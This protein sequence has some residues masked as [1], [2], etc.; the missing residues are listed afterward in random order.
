VR[1]EGSGGEIDPGRRRRDWGALGLARATG[2]RVDRSWTVASKVAGQR[3][4]GKESGGREV[5]PWGL[6][7]TR[8]SDSREDARDGRAGDK[9]KAEPRE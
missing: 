1:W 6:G 3:R 8:G 2:V 5:I 4:E 9:S 7:E